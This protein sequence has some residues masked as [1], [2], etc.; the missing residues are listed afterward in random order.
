MVQF[1]VY[2]RETD[3]TVDVE[4]D[5]YFKDYGVLINLY[6]HVLLVQYGKVICCANE[7]YGV[8]ITNQN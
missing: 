3:K 4:T 5:K 1:E 7:R 2:D 8:R 6:G